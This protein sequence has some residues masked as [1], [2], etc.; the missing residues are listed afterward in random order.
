MIYFVCPTC[1]Y[2]I[3][4]LLWKSENFNYKCPKCES[5]ILDNFKGKAESKRN[6]KDITIK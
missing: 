3:T 2:K 4:N 1:S 5:E 6:T